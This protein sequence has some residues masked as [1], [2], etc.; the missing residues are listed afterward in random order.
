MNITVFGASGGIGGHVVALAVQRGHSVRAV[1]RQRRPPR[2]PAGAEILIAPDI[3]DPAFT[4]CG[5]GR[6]R[7]GLAR[8][9][10]TSP[11]ATTPAPP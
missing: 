6:R 5:N 8:P 7:G 10:R 11:P 4:T 9:G 1:Y 3:F 2:R